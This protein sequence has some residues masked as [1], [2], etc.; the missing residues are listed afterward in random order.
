MNIEPDVGI[1]MPD[2]KAVL[3]DF[4][5][6][7][8]AACNSAEALGLDTSATEEEKSAAEQAMYKYAEN[9]EK[10][11][12]E[13]AKKS[14][15]MTP[16][17]Y[18]EVKGMLDEFSVRVV[19]NAMQIRLLVTNKLILET[20]D[21]DPRVRIRALELLGKITDVGLFTEKSEVTVHHRSSA[22]LTEI[23]REK[24][25]RLMN[26]DNV[27]D[28][29][30]VEVNGEK[31]DLSEELGLPDEDLEELEKVVEKAEA[32]KGEKPNDAAI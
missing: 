17:I 31:V 3:A 8:I 4:Q 9:P 2:D 18:R 7:A 6:R 21:E 13:V 22:E 24:I 1:P 16:A 12:K 32:A 20:A 23:L 27:T 15:K 11:S 10:A 29:E 19:D 30:A 5:E 25:R 14:T 26:P 28:V